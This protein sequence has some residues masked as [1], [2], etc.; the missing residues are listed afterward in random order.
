MYKGDKGERTVSFFFG[1]KQESF[2]IA[3]I[4]PKEELSPY[5]RDLQTL[6]VA[7]LAFEMNDRRAKHPEERLVD[8]VRHAANRVFITGVPFRFVVLPTSEIAV[9][10]SGELVGSIKV[11]LFGPNIELIADWEEDEIPTIRGPLQEDESLDELK[12]SLQRLALSIRRH[13]VEDKLQ[14]KS[15]PAK[16]YVDDNGCPFCESF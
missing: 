1:D 10:L 11:G 9:M 5:A 2:T 6:S 13:R 4:G 8:M 15:K 16:T 12:A 7:R 14:G 3:P